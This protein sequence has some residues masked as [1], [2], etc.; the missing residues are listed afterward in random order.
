[1]VQS[2]ERKK[3]SEEKL[4]SIG[5]HPNQNIPALEDETMIQLRSPQ[6]VASRALLLHALM[7]VIFYEK[8]EEVVRWVQNEGLWESLT[9]KE[10]EI[11]LVPISNLDDG[12]KVWRQK[13][14]QSNLLTW[15]IEG[16]WVLLWSLGK[17][18]LLDLPKVKCDGGL[19][20]GCVPEL[21]QSVQSFIKD[22]QFR[23]ISILLDEVDFTYRI[24]RSFH[25]EG[26]QQ[27]FLQ[28]FDQ[29]IVYER[30]HALAWLVNWLDEWD[31]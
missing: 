11:F 22:A 31:D 20:R 29:M 10:K 15:R 5:L 9:P 13:S 17:I 7:G 28:S 4:R 8:P 26:D 12:E 23:N 25:E 6:E 1:M 14:L 18:D 24:H 27:S 21:G 3:R 2:I 30:I 16:L 19:L